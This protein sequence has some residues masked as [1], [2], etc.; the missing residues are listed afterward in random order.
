LC[1]PIHQA[2]SDDDVECVVTGV[3][4]FAERELV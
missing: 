3:R 1:L 2:L 4:E